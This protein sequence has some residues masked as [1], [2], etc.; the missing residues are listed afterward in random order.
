MPCSKQFGLP[1][2]SSSRYQVSPV[3]ILRLTAEAE[4]RQDY[5]RTESLFKLSSY[6]ECFSATAGMH[7]EACA[8]V[9][10]IGDY[11]LPGTKESNTR[12]R[13]RLNPRE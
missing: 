13:K 11:G 6:L 12:Q 3:E 10:H 9:Y 2:N 8:L 7:S 4:A 5:K 1:G